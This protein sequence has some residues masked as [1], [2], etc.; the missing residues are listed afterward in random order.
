MLRS[1]SLTGRDTQPDETR[2]PRVVGK[3]AGGVGTRSSG[4]VVVS[5]EGSCAL[6]L[7]TYRLTI[8]SGA[9]ANSVV[10][11]EPITAIGGRI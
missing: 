3:P 10:V 5:V 9:Q 4:T 1:S 7:A 11:A 6:T 8:E 2:A